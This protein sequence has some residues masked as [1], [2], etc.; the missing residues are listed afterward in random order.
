M[1]SLVKII[2]PIHGL[3]STVPDRN[4]D[5]AERKEFLHKETRLINQLREKE[6]EVVSLKSQ[7]PFSPQSAYNSPPP[8]LSHTKD[9][10]GDIAGGNVPVRIE[11]E[12]DR[13]ASERAEAEIVA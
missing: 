10:A 2:A 1:L 13:A 4:S 6:S 11:P 9:D 3:S 12:A 7:P 5:A 8:E